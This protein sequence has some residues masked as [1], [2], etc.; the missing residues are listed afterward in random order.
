MK[1]SLTILGAA[2]I[3]ALGLYF[4]LRERSVPA[5]SVGP[6]ETEPFPARDTSAAETRQP[7]GDVAAST[8]DPA[9]KQPSD[10]K[11]APSDETQLERRERDPLPS[12]EPLAAAEDYKEVNPAE[13]SEDYELV[14]DLNFGLLGFSGTQDIG[15]GGTRI[16]NG[17][18]EKLLCEEKEIA[19]T[20]TKIEDGFIT[21]KEYGRIKVSAGT[22]G[23]LS[24][25]LRPSQKAKFMQLKTPAVQK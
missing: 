17:T 3:I 16:L 11:Q 14:S 19:V 10:A 18:F 13:L 22:F 5:T 20:A 1:N 21:T 23:G 12:Q 25:Y 7:E 2:A 9:P 6:T 15:E 8:G 24:V 4:G